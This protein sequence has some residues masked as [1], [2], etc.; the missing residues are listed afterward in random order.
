M[1]RGRG[2]FPQGSSCPVVLK[3][4]LEA[5]PFCLL[6]CHRLW[7]SFPGTFDWGSV[8]NFLTTLEWVQPALQPPISIGSRATELT[9]FGLFLF[10]SPLLKEYAY[11]SLFLRLLRCFTS[12][13][14]LARA[15]GFSAPYRALRRGG[16]PHSDIL[17]SKAICASP[18]L[19]AAYHVLHRLLAPRHPP[20]ALSSLMR[21]A[22]ER[23][24]TLIGYS[25]V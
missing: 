25:R 12:P 24:K 20:Y 17:G 1:P 3:N 16:F 14:S 10:R 18:G 15:Y 22:T 4:R 7:W 13:G 11:L 21:S 9:G 5:S 8:C 6:D 2:R 23:L 19:I